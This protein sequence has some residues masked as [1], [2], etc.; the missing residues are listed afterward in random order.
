[1]VNTFISSQ[2]IRFGAARIGGASLSVFTHAGL[3][4]LA[5]VGSG[6][7][8]T[9]DSHLVSAIPAE[10]V[11][12]V[13]TRPELGRAD[14]RDAVARAAK[15]VARWMIPDLTKLRASIDATLTV[16]PVPTEVDVELDIGA[17]A[18]SSHD[19][20]DLDTSALVT[21]EAMRAFARPDK[22]GA[23]SQ[24]V[25]ERTA[26]P[27]RGNPSPQ[28]PGPLLRAGVEGTFLAQF[29]VDSTGRV[30]ARTLAFPESAHPMFVRAVRDA[31]IRSRFLPAELAGVRVRQLVQ[32]QFTFVIG[33]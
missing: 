4:A 9:F 11:L 17:N 31:L 12:F 28:Y 29:V 1:M 10:R 3:I 22:N 16:T 18:T 2:G 8:A 32:Q 20:G 33:R 7:S 15:K 26:W 21:A 27:R 25:V 5:V 14:A 19:F 24:D 13:A 30:D 23:Y 6:K